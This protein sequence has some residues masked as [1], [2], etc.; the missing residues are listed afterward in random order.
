MKIS[1]GKVGQF[2]DQ[3]PKV[4]LEVNKFSNVKSFDQKV[5]LDMENTILT[6][7][8]KIFARSGSIFESWFE[9]C[10]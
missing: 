6:N 4:V 5:P 8:V 10:C 2:S 3:S 9:S 1:L 7:L